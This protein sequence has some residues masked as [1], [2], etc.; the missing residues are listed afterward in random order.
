MQVKSGRRAHSASTWALRSIGSDGMCGVD[1]G[2]VIYKVRPMCARNFEIPKRSLGVIAMDILEES[3]RLQ[4]GD[5]NNL[6]FLFVAALIVQNLGNGA[7]GLPAGRGHWRDSF[8]FR[9]T[10]HKSE[11]IQC[12]D[13]E[14][15]MKHD[16]NESFAFA[17]AMAVIEHN[18]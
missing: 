5:N 8:P 18:L 10:I 12:N 14:Q 3:D 6:R 16:H 2:I 11:S 13:N 7:L 4:I 9:N 17:I 1:A 15:Q